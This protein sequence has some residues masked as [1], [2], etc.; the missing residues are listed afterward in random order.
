M[1][2][3]LMIRAALIPASA[4]RSATPV[5]KR[6]GRFGRFACRSGDF[7]PVYARHGEISYHQVDVGLAFDKIES[8]S[9]AAGFQHPAP[10]DSTQSGT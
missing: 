4:V 1:N 10:R 2:G 6:I 7:H 8:G 9:A 3:L 5:T